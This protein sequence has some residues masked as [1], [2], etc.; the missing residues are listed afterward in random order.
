MVETAAPR[1]PGRP[2]DPRKRA[3]LLRA[4]ATLFTTRGY[5]ETS[6]EQVAQAAGVS[7]L[8]VYSHFEG[9]EH[10]FS[11]VIVAKC[12]E[13][14]GGRHLDRYAD[15]PPSVALP[16]IAQRFIDLILNEEI[17]ALHQMLVGSARSHPELCQRFWDAG[18][19]PSLSS[20]AALLRH[21]AATG[22]LSVTDADRAADHFFALLHG[23]LHLCAA[24]GIGR[25]PTRRLIRDHV[26]SAVGLFLRA[27]A[28]LP[29]P[30]AD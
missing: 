13:H 9:K 5:A 23:R 30:A 14:F 12:E 24:L 21:Y 8:T 15:Q 20:L 26:S 27:H 6:I 16:E 10:L 28:P 22:Q 18:P 11:E 1:V 25:R 19:A 17:V 29:S 7:K 2:K 3:A 4:A